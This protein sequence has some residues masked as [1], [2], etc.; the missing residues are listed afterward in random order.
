MF[1]TVDWAPLLMAVDTV[2]ASGSPSRAQ[3]EAV[4]C[5]FEEGVVSHLVAV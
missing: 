1:R 2:L 3:S 5:V 4:L